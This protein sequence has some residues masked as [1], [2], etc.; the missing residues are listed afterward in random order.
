M[1]NPSIQHSMLL[2]YVISVYTILHHSTT[3]HII[4]YYALSYVQG[5]PPGP[6]APEVGAAL[7]RLLHRGDARAGQPFPTSA[8]YCLCCCFFRL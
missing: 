1:I 2:C 5:A 7:Q 6:V 3:Y 4:T 8:S